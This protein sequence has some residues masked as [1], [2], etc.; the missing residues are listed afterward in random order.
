MLKLCCVFDRSFTQRLVCFPL[1]CFSL[2]CGRACIGVERILCCFAEI[3]VFRAR[4]QMAPGF[5]PSRLATP[6][7][8]PWK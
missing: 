5:A 4:V 1:N 8:V 7:M 2:Q 6:F 3:V